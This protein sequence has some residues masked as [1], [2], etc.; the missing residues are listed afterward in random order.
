MKKRIIAS[1]LALAL[2]ATCVFAFAACN[3]GKNDVP[4]TFEMPVGERPN[5]ST[6]ESLTANKA[7][8]DKGV[9]ESA[10][11]DDDET[12]DQDAIKKAVMALY[13]TANES[14]INT[15][16]SL[17][18]QESDAGIEMAKVIMHSFN[19][20]N[21]DKW[22][23]QLATSVQ[24]ASDDPVY[25]VMAAAAAAF[26]GYLK[27]AY[28]NGDGNYW[29]FAGKGVAYCCDCS[30]ATF[31]YAKFEI[32]EKDHPFESPLTLD[33]FNNKLHVLSGSIH[34]INNM[35]FCAEIIADNATIKLENGLY[36]VDFAIDMDSDAE[37]VEKWFAKPQEDMKEGGQ[38]INY[39]N[40]YRATLQMWDNGYAKYFESHADRNA[41]S[42]SGKPVDKYS[43]VW[44][45]K[46]IL[47]LV[48]QDVDIKAKDKYSL[49]D[50]V[51]QYIE[52]YSDPE[53]VNTIQLG[54]FDIF[55][56][57][58]GCIAV[59]I[60]VIVVT[61]EVLVKKG[62]LPKLAAKREKAKQKRLAKKAAKNGKKIALIDENSN[63][64]TIDGVFDEEDETASQSSGD[65][66]DGN[67]AQSSG[68]SNGGNNA[69]S[70]G[71]TDDGN[72]AQSDIDASDE[73]LSLIHI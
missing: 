69:Q 8:I 27:V 43:Y 73:E 44:T 65:T 6:L 30:I 18:V 14:R 37:L 66:D 36:T 33:D 58:V 31:P 42:A 53:Y 72:D 19:L 22:Y 39:Y 61:I 28:T 21:G 7:I 38:K 10:K 52:A 20:R 5:Y 35:D 16:L 24:P 3:N 70:N 25:K 26:A 50:N 17:V 4:A 40:S 54:F 59:V 57:V 1:V 55:G 71:D 15:P 48:G 51:N 67:D 12:K 23:Y 64:E 49:L 56:I 34:E 29:F 2:I 9:A 63:G 13:T 60:I 41:G 62:K 45:E 32:Q 68:D 11:A 47:D 46:E